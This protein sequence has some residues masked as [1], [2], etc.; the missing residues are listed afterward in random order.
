VKQFHSL[1]IVHGDIHPKNL[2]KWKGK[3]VVLD[4]DSSSPVG[5]EWKYSHGTWGYSF[6]PDG[7]SNF[8]D[9]L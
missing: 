7:Y 8:R 5:I 9:D 2:A 6:T 4:F 3:T 1:N